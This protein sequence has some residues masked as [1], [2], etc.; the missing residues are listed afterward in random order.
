MLVK[1]VDCHN[2]LFKYPCI[3]RALTHAVREWRHCC[4]AASVTAHD[5]AMHAHARMHSSSLCPASSAAL[6]GLSVWY[7]LIALTER[8]TLQNNRLANTFSD[9]ISLDFYGATAQPLNRSLS[10]A[11]CA[12]MPFCWKTY[13]Q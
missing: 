4:T 6:S 5:L 8:P 2:E 12:S 13:T 11:L 7:I 1:C 9:T 3:H 10:R